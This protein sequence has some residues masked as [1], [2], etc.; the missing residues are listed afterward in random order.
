M[1]FN[2]ESLMSFLNFTVFE[3]FCESLYLYMWLILSVIWLHFIIDITW[4]LAAFFICKLLT[5]HICKDSQ[6]KAIKS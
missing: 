2:F 5:F 3:P 1:T 4:L 6:I